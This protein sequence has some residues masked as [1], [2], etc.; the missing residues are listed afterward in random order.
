MSFL[1]QYCPQECRILGVTMKLIYLFLLSVITISCSL[2]NDSYESRMQKD[3][4]QMPISEIVIELETDSIGNELDTITIK[5][6]KYDTK[7]RIRYT[8]TTYDS[9]KSELYY[10]TNKDIFHSETFSKGKST[11]L[12]RTT[13]DASGN[14]ITAIQTMLDNGQLDTVHMSYDRSLHPNGETKEL[15][16]TIDHND[17]PNSKGVLTKNSLGQPISEI[18]ITN[19]DTS[20]SQSWQYID[21]VLVSSTAHTQSISGISSTNEMF[22]DSNGINRIVFTMMEDKKILS[23]RT[24]E[25]FYNKAGYQVRSIERDSISG[26]V[27]Y[28]KYITKK[29]Q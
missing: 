1:N 27:T 4:D 9:I 28:M 21:T 18:L 20:Q 5:R 6:N 12:F 10:T 3:I 16:I 15:V 2:N 8:E 14:V 25:Y 11:S 13:S 26:T 17:V 7:G 19:G 29:I 22:F 24:T 23:Q